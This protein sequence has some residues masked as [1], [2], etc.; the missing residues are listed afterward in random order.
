[1]R[2][3]PAG[4]MVPSAASPLSSMYFGCAVAVALEEGHLELELR[5]FF[6]TIAW[7]ARSTS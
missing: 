1:M 7:P 2:R 6:A 3:R 4:K 5:M